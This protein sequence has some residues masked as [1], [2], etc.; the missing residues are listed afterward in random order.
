MLVDCNGG[1]V[2]KCNI[3]IYTR[4]PQA[5]EFG[6]RVAFAIMTWQVELNCQLSFNLMKPS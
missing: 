6:V 3:L 4:D 5:P 1:T 2:N